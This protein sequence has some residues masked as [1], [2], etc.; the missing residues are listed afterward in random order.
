MTTI[1]N[2]EELDEFEPP[3]IEIHPSTTDKVENPSSMGNNENCPFCKGSLR[4]I[5]LTDHLNYCPD[6]MRELSKENCYLCK[7]KVKGFVSLHLIAECN[8]GCNLSR[9]NILL[10]CELNNNYFQHKMEAQ[11]WNGLSEYKS[12]FEKSAIKLAENK[13]GKFHMKN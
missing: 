3:K 9:Q 6:Y 4:L 5:N 12:D 8:I 13:C 10:E 7:N 2:T 1:F 11:S